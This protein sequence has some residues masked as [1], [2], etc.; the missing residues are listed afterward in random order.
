MGTT[1]GSAA[2]GGIYREL[3]TVQPAP[4]SAAASA[5]SK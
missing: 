1:T 2:A 5:P 3:V 4:P